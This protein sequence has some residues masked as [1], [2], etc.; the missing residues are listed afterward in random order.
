[1]KSLQSVGRKCVLWSDCVHV[2]IPVPQRSP[3]LFIPFSPALPVRNPSPLDLPSF[4]VSPALP[5]EGLRHA[6]QTPPRGRVGV[7][8]VG[9]QSAGSDW[10]TE[11]EEE[12][13]GHTVGHVGAWCAG[14]ELG[15]FLSLSACIV[16]PGV[17][18]CGPLSPAG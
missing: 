5:W 4:P 3:C 17:F 9:G 13:G 1:M 8:V 10:R 6:I 18:L 2:K 16:F 7:A 12:R 15:I 11:M 14:Q